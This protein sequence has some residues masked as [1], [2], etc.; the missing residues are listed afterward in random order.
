MANAIERGVISAAREDILA[1]GL[2][3]DE[4][5]PVPV[6]SEDS[7]VAIPPGSLLIPPDQRNLAEIERM[8]VQAALSEAGGQKSRA[9]DMLGINRTTLYNKIKDFGS[10]GDDSGS[11]GP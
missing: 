3:L 11:D 8:I 1:A 7:E 6:P 10:I 5:L 4:E 9:A 2:I